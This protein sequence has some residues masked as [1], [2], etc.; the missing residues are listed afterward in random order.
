[1]GRGFNI[2]KV[3]GPICHGSEVDNTLERVVD[4]PWE[5]V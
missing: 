3:R 1:M 2:P 4:I 5:G